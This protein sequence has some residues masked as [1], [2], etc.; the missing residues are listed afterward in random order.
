MKTK[1]Y[2]QLLIFFFL[3]ASFVFSQTYNEHDLAKLK[4][5]MEQSADGK[6]NI[7]LLWADAPTTLDEDGANWVPDLKGIVRWNKEGR[8]KYIAGKYKDLNGKI[9]FSDC[10]GLEEVYLRNN[11]FTELNLDGCTALTM[12]YVCMNQI[13]SI[14]IKGCYNIKGLSASSNKYTTFDVSNRKNLK[15]I[16]IPNNKLNSINV[17]GCSALT[18]LVFTKGYVTSVDLKDCPN[19]TTLECYGNKITSLDLSKN[20]NLKTLTIY[21]KSALGTFT[22]PLKSLNISGCSQLSSYDFSIFSDL[23]ELNISNCGL[24]SIDL[25]KYP[26][27]KKLDAGSQKLSL[28]SLTAEAGAIKVPVLDQTDLLVTPSNGGLFSDGYVSW[29][30]LPQGNGTYNYGFTTSLPEGVTGIPFSGIVSVPWTNNVSV[31]NQE[32][33]ASV[34]TF[35]VSNGI[36]HINMPVAQT[37]RV[38]TLSGQIV[39]QTTSLSEVQLSLNKGIYIVQLGNGV[40]RKVAVE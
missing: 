14:N 13:A 16:Y 28:E 32:V 22:N 38:Y 35:S 12:L 15:T 21:S 30:N 8:L 26:N 7:D 1:F 25:T 24:S 4:F 5:F 9:D 11:N 37:V 33:G 39:K 2:I 27:L 40:T 29:T 36:L 20:I 10:L 31:A 34:S 17:K 3:P 18:S 19:L 23:E 6:R